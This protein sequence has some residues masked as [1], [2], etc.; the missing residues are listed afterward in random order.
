MEVADEGGES[1]DA[2]G[3]G[4][5]GDGEAGKIFGKVHIG[6]AFQSTK[7]IINLFSASSGFILKIF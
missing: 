5:K 3:G 2:Q 4:D 1:K 6:V 7:R